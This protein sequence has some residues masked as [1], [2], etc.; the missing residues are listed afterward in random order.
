[1]TFLKQVI[2]ILSFSPVFI[3]NF[4]LT[5]LANPLCDR[6][7]FEIAVASGVSE[8]NRNTELAVTYFC[9]N[10]LKGVQQLID[11]GYITRSDAYILADYLGVRF[12]GKTRSMEGRLYGLVYRELL[13]IG[14]CTACA[15]NAAS[16]YVDS[17]N[18]YVGRLVERSLEGDKIAI[19][20]LIDYQKNNL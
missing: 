14:L 12:E 8:A 3:A 17:P 13:D 6:R 5:S 9:E 10:Q 1:M 11:A 7:P 15:S 18:S 2:L 4:C 16:Q 20:L 19:E